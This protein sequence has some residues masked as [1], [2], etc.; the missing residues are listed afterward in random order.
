MHRF[1][2]SYSFDYGKRKRKEYP[3]TI[4][5]NKMKEY[6]KRKI[7]SG[8]EQLYDNEKV[9]LYF[10]KKIDYY[11]QKIICNSVNTR[12]NNYVYN[13]NYFE[14]VFSLPCVFDMIDSCR[15]LEIIKYDEHLGIIIFTLV[16]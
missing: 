3:R 6:K 10:E 13:F 14:N 2:K 4:S 11:L 9:N 15:Y 12:N 1:N 8:S 5:E 16:T 7:L